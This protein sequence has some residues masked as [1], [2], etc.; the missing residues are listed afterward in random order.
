[1]KATVDRFEG[2]WAVCEKP[3]R[4][5]MNIEKNKLPAG[6]KEGDIIII[7]NDSIEVDS[8][9]TVKRKKDIQKLMDDIW[10]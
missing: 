10:K 4:T 2:E 8:G 6:A 7:E 1:M 5:M 3:D 9:E